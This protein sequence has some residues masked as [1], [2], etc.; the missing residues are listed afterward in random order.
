MTGAAQLER[1]T[2][3]FA[4]AGGFAVADTDKTPIKLGSVPKMAL[5]DQIAQP[6]ATP[7]TEPQDAGSPAPTGWKALMNLNRVEGSQGATIA[8]SSRSGGAKGDGPL[9]FSLAALSNAASVRSG[10]PG[11]WLDAASVLK[12]DA[13]RVR[14]SSSLGR[15]AA[16][17]L[18]LA[19][20]L[21]F[22][23]P[24]DPRSDHARQTLSSAGCLF[25]PSLH[26]HRDR[27]EPSDRL[28]V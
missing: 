10:N 13:V 16:V 22:T 9:Y 1:P 17:L 21:T 7:T 15:H 12:R 11:D 14:N 4:E 26:R 28:A 3:K 6:P 25:S 20:A 8:F 2:E 23:L 24:S 18:T 27:E 19:D 5:V